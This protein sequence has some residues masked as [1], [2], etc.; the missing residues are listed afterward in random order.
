MDE[1][2]NRLHRGHSGVALQQAS[3][4]MTLAQPLIIVD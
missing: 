1:I 3:F 4:H 2:G